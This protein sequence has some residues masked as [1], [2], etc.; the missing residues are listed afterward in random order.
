MPVMLVRPRRAAKGRWLLPAL[1]IGG[2]G[3]TFAV[4]SHWALLSQVLGLVH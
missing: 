2:G 4:L 1:A 3:A